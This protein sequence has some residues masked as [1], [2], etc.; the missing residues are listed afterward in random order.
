MEKELKLDEPT[1][2][3]WLAH[4][5]M[6]A[7]KA[8]ESHLANEEETGASR[9][10]CA[11]DRRHLPRRQGSAHRLLQVRRLGRVEMELREIGRPRRSA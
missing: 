9:T 10:R 4:W 7:L 11:D 5:S 6:E 1:R 2:N 3:K 8:I